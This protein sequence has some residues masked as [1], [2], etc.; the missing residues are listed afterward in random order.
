MVT[1]AVILIGL[2]LFLICLLQVVGLPS[3][4]IILVLVFLWKLLGP[5]SSAADLTW[6]FIIVMVVIAAIGELLEWGIQV[7][8]GSKFG[9]SSK[10]NWVGIIGSIIGGILLLPLFFGFGAILGALA[11]AYLGCL[12][13]ELACRRSFKEANIAAWGAFLGRFLGMALKLGIGIAIVVMSVW[14]MWP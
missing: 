13:V 8:L 14:R 7:K 2:V 3:N 5:A 6:T 4:W 9:S 1:T 12:I 11:G 10:G